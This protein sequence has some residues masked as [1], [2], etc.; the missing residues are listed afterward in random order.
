ERAKTRARSL[1]WTEEVDLLEEEMRRVLQFLTWRAGWWEEQ[2]GRRG[3][4][5]GSQREGETA[6]ATRQAALLIDL[7]DVFAQKWSGLAEL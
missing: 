5:E 7:R 1:R 4:P 6:Y 3:L 2:I